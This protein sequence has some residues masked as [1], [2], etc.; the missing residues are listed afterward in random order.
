MAAVKVPSG[1]KSTRA[2]CAQRGVDRLGARDALLRVPALDREVAAATDEGAQERVAEHLALGH[3]DDVERQ[4][5]EQDG[6]VDVRGVVRGEDQ[7]AARRQPLAAGRLEPAAEE[8]GA[9]RGSRERDTAQAKR[10]L[11]TSTTSSQAASSTG[12]SATASQ[13]A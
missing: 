10:R 12:G 3:E 1:K 5:R 4:Q 9:R 7:R 13:R 8:A 11:G 6:D 2:P